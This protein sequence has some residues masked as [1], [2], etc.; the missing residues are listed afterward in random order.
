MDSVS[1]LAP[2]QTCGR[3]EMRSAARLP[4]GA[5]QSALA[6]PGCVRT[7]LLARSPASPHHPAPAAALTTL[8]EPK[9]NAVVLGSLILM[10]TAAKR[11]GLYSALRARSAIAL[12]SRVHCRLT[13]ATTFCA[14]QEHHRVWL[15]ASLKGAAARGSRG[16]PGGYLQLRHDAARM[17]AAV[18]LRLLL[19]LG[20]RAWAGLG[21]V[22]H[23][24]RSGASGWARARLVASQQRCAGLD[25]GA[26]ARE[27]GGA[28]ARGKLHGPLPGEL[29]HEVDSPWSNGNSQQKG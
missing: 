23:A 17:H 2:V 15:R 3:R 16:L 21:C 13:V 20:A 19:G 18:D 1:L 7:G 11:L 28:G 25:G 5:G 14:Q 12:R 8:P 4:V 10:I 22:G 24:A 26:G 27:N 9:I 6:P 29:P